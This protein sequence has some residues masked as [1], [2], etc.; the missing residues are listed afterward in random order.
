MS[1]SVW[2]QR[3]Q[4]NR[5]PHPWDSTGKNT[6]VGCHFLLQCIK[7][8]M[9]VKSPSRVWL[10]VT[11]WTAPYQAPPSI[12]FSRQEYWSGVPFPSPKIVPTLKENMVYSSGPQPFWQRDQFP[13]TT[14]PW[15]GSWDDLGLIQVHYIYC[16]LY[17]YFVAISGYSALT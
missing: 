6:G 5:L 16:I 1:D 12:G 14:F 8:K 15:T 17:F 9:K 3:Q 11:P 4:P 2:P 13:W 10:L 7:V